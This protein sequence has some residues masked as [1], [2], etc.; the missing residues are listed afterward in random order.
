MLTQSRIERVMH[1]MLTTRVLLDIR[2]EAGV[3]P[4]SSRV[5]TELNY[6]HSSHHSEDP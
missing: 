2:A 5:L 4:D 1:S 6:H 3:D